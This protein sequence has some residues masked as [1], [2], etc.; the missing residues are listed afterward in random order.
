[1]WLT[2]FTRRRSRF[3]NA[4]GIINMGA[5]EEVLGTTACVANKRHCFA[6]ILLRCP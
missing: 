5:E 2:V 6:N 1:M 4:L 3:C